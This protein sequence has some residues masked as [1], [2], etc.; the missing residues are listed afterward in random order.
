MRGGDAEW[1]GYLLQRGMFVRRELVGIRKQGEALA[2]QWQFDVSLIDEIPNLYCGNDDGP[3]VVGCLKWL[4]DVVG[5]AV[6][7]RNCCVHL[8]LMMTSVVT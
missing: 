6:W 5:S 4:M 8:S 1:L 7:Y 2:I 3:F